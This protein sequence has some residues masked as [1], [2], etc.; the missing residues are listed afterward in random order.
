[1]NRQVKKFLVSSLPAALRHLSLVGG[2]APKAY[3][4]FPGV[5]PENMD[6]GREWGPSRLVHLLPPMRMFTWVLILLTSGGG[7]S[8][9]FHAKCREHSTR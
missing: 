4:L 1:M 6:A 7:G 9:I 8:G 2:A 3:Q 5:R